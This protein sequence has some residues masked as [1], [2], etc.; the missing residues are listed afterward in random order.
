MI[1]IVRPDLTGPARWL[2]RKRL[3]W[4][5]AQVQAQIHS[6]IRGLHLPKVKVKLKLKPP[7]LP[8]PAELESTLVQSLARSRARVESL[9]RSRA[10]VESIVRSPALVESLVRNPA[11]VESIVRNPALV[12][13]IVRNRAQIQSV[14]RDRVRVQSIVRKLGTAA[15]GV[16]MFAVTAADGTVIVNRPTPLPVFTADARIERLRV[17]FDAYA[18]PAPRHIADYLRVADTYGLDYRILP[19]LSVRES[20]CGQYQ[21]MNN[22]WGWDSGQSGFGSIA[23]GIEYVARQLA[24]AP[25]YK[26]KTLDQLLWTYNPRAAYPGEV[27]KL[28]ARI[29][30]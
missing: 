28:M 16:T 26:G 3:A 11:L 21:K 15:V 5:Q 23:S 25:Q 14:L 1:V 24:E 27:K 7:I 6:P 9:V 17:F 19:A 29:E 20:T 13:A 4:N 8:S 10:R 30:P 18:C 2:A 12:E 22:R